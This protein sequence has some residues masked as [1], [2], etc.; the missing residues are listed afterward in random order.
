[1]NRNLINKQEIMNFRKFSARRRFPKCRRRSA[2]GRTTPAQPVAG[3]CWRTVAQSAAG[4]AG[5]VQLIGF[6]TP[7]SDNGRTAPKR[8]LH[9]NPANREHPH[10]CAP[11]ANGRTGN[12]IRPSPV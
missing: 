6:P 8:P 4:T 7:E 3:L 11:K 2:H 5:K 10:G 9:G 12:P 1:M